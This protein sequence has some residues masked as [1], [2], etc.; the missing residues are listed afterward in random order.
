MQLKKKSKY[1]ITKRKSENM[2]IYANYNFIT[3]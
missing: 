1:N 2:E 3:Y